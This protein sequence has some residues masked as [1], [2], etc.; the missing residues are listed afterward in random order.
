MKLW[1]LMVLF[2][3]FFFNFA[4]LWKFKMAPATM[5]NTELLWRQM[6]GNFFVN[7][8]WFMEAGDLF[9]LFRP[10]NNIQT[11]LR[12][13]QFKSIYF[14]L[15]LEAQQKVYRYLRDRSPED[16]PNRQGHHNTL[17]R[18]L[19]KY[20]PN[21]EWLLPLPRVRRTASYYWVDRTL[22]SKH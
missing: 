22:R 18:L 1:K 13:C 2:V 9:A 15:Q 14:S 11:P 7:L 17:W 4:K 19:W 16:Q 21:C 10:I 8:Y 20:R 12:R 3:T 6:A 5:L